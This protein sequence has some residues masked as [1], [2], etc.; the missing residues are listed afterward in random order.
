M[1]LPAAEWTLLHQLEVEKMAHRH[2][3]GPI[4]WEQFPFSRCAKLPTKMICNTCKNLGP[5]KPAGCEH[6]LGRWGRH[7][8]KQ[9]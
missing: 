6:V 8:A 3:P 4:W 9:L 7:A 5:D 1:A 2:P